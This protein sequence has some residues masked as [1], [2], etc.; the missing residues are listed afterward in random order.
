M[1]IFHCPA[2]IRK[3]FKSPL[4]RCHKFVRV[5]ETHRVVEVRVMELLTVFNFT[6]N[7]VTPEVLYNRALKWPQCLPKIM[8]DVNCGIRNSW[9]FYWSFFILII[10]AK[11]IPYHWFT[12]T[13][14]N[15]RC[16]FRPTRVYIWYWWNEKGNS[17]ICQSFAKWFTLMDT[18][19]GK[20]FLVFIN[21][22]QKY[23]TSNDRAL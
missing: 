17:I 10:L 3:S 12:N 9:K 23:I 19:N 14:G 15:H 20:P 11:L 6:I 4:G 22:Y 5:K 8:M 1:Q 2:G 21:Q 7:D 13:W 18:S 16:Q